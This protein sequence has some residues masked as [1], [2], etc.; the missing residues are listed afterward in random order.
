MGD[1]CARVASASPALAAAS[2][3]TIGAAFS[4]DEFELRHAELVKR[5]DSRAQAVSKQHHALK[6]MQR[7]V[8]ALV[9]PQKQSVEEMRRQLSELS[10]ESE[11][12][13]QAFE[14]ARKVKKAAEDKVQDLTDMKEAL[15]ARLTEIVAQ[16]E[17]A[18]VLKLEELMGTLEQLDTDAR[19]DG[20]SRKAREA[21][22]AQAAKDGVRRGGAV[23]SCDGERSVHA[24]QSR[25]RTAAEASAPAFDGF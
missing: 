12:A 21:E 25:R 5:V 3:P 23:S 1:E 8:S 11:A 18:K 16:N 13:R 7:E 22:S 20:A 19:D 4:L 10:A 6:R 17:A 9:G 15:I 14:A 2:A 24:E